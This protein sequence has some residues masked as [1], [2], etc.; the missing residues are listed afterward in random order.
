[1]NKMN[2]FLTLSLAPRSTP[3]IEEETITGLLQ[4]IA[5]YVAPNGVQ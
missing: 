5:T 2:I 4:T 3:Q 1:M